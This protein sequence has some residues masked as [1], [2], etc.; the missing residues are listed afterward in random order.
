MWIKVPGGPVPLWVKEDDCRLPNG[1]L[2]FVRKPREPIVPPPLPSW[3]VAPPGSLLR[4]ESVTSSG[5]LLDES[6]SMRGRADQVLAFYDRMAEAAGLTK[7][8]LHSYG[9]WPGF[10]AELDRYRLTLDALDYGELVFWSVELNGP[11]GE[12]IV[13]LPHGL[14]FIERDE[15]RLTLQHDATGQRYVGAV[16]DSEPP[17]PPRVEIRPIAWSRL[18]DW[19]QCGLEGHLQGEVLRDPNEPDR[20][21]WATLSLDRFP[22][23]VSSQKAFEF[24]LASLDAHG[25][26]ATG[27]LRPERSYYVSLCGSQRTAHVQSEVDGSA[28]ITVADT[29]GLASLFVRY[30]PAPG[31]PFPAAG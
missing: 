29:I 13:L 24:C 12:P 19:L 21:W 23:R 20:Q 2:A 14:I 9:G 8:R 16:R 4:S 7:T 18:P 6:R 1:E 31:T 22:K 5:L 3:F 30:S 25:F 28:M 10:S 15:E 26:D 11:V 17:R 27:A